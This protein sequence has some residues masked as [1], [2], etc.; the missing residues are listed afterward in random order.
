[1]T[2][3]LTGKVNNINK[4]SNSRILI[5]KKDDLDSVTNNL[6]NPIF[7]WWMLQ[8]EGLKEVAYF[9]KFAFSVGFKELYSISDIF[10]LTTIFLSCPAV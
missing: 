9:K 4:H 1:M 8:R 2:R 7:V 3:D 6:F 5:I 10:K